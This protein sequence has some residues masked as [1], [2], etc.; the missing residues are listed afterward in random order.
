MENGKERERKKLVS[1]RGSLWWPLWSRRREREKWEGVVVVAG[2]GELTFSS[3]LAALTNNKNTYTEL[4]SLNQLHYTHG[5]VGKGGDLLPTGT[6]CCPWRSIP[7]RFYCF[8]PL[9]CPLTKR[10]RFGNISL[11]THSLFFYITLDNPV[12]IFTIRLG[13][14][15]WKGSKH[16]AN[17]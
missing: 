3:S 6:S 4:A 5:S 12:S 16:E 1:A 9:T 10:R 14:L 17:I 13:N 8:P 11:N 2:T 15:N 7:F